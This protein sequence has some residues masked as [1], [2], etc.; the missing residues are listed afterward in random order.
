MPATIEQEHDIGLIRV[1]QYVTDGQGLRIAA[2]VD[3]E[4]LRRVEELIED[5]HALRIIAERKDKP[6]LDY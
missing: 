5:L 1:T 2:I 3:I 4:E 6:T